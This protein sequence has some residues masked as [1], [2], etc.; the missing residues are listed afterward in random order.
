MTIS[1]GWMT[2]TLNTQYMICTNPSSVFLCMIEFRWWNLTGLLSS[3][4]FYCSNRLW[5]LKTPTAFFHWVS[6]FVTNSTN[7]DSRVGR[8]TNTGWSFHFMAPRD[9]EAFDTNPHTHRHGCTYTHVQEEWICNQMQMAAMWFP[10]C[11]GN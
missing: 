2:R 6:S 7:Q 3:F 11:S 8:H 4:G 1:I 9:Q 10:C 5:W